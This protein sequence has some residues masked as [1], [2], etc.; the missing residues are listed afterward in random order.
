MVDF[1]RHIIY[2]GELI[3]WPVLEHHRCVASLQTL[4]LDIIRWSNQTEFIPNST[5][6]FTRILNLNVKSRFDV[7]VE[8]LHRVR[9]QMLQL[10]ISK[11][12]LYG[13][14]WMVIVTVNEKKVSSPIDFIYTLVDV[15]QRPF[16]GVPLTSDPYFLN[17]T[18]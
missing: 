10:P 17:Q 16:I 6:C 15:E 5:D 14:G 2:S 18:T 8:T 12:L 7:Q 4:Y 13:F 11:E 3:V 9:L 1:I